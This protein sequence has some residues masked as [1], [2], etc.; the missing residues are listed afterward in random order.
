MNAPIDHFRHCPVCGCL[1]A[2]RRGANVIHCSAC[3]F[4]YHFNPTVAAGA[5][6]VR[7]DGVALFIRRAKDPCKGKLALPGGFIE[8]GETAETSLRREVLEEVGLEFGALAY[9]CSQVNSYDYCSVT[10]PV[11]DLFFSAWLEASAEPQALED[12]AEICWIHPR[13]VDPD[14]IAFPSVRE[15]VRVFNEQFIDR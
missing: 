2:E 8:I 3:G 4:L 9:L 11:L 15:A 12:V 1:L 7:P 14:Q 13:R 5:I 10:Y 6:L